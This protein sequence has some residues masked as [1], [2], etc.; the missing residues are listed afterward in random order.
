M[1]Y[2]PQVNGSDEKVFPMMT[3]ADMSM[4]A[5]QIKYINLYFCGLNFFTEIWDHKIMLQA[6][7]KMTRRTCCAKKRKSGT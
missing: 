7:L 2:I 1:A 6:I 3:T 5:I 4:K